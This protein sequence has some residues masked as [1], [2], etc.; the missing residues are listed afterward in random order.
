M[1]VVEASGRWVP[2]TFLREVTTP[3]KFLTLTAAAPQTSRCVVPQVALVT[4]FHKKAEKEQCP[5]ISKGIA[6]HVVSP[7][8]STLNSCAC[9][10][11]LP[12]HKKSLD[13]DSKQSPDLS[14]R[15]NIKL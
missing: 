7:T 13:L 15:S 6:R 1:D 2:L 14:L 11:L 10:T 5:G 3:A 9:T 4:R 12:G 8:G